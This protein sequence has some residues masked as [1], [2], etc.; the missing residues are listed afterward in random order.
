MDFESSVIRSADY[1]PEARTLDVVFTAGRHYR[2]FGVPES[3][4]GGLITASSAG[5]YFNAHIRDQ[6]D[7]IELEASRAAKPK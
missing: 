3:E 2:Y 6:Y 7:F 5:A 1:D 4:Y